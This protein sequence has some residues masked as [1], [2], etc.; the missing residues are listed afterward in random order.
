MVRHHDLADGQVR[1]L[2]VHDDRGRAALPEM[3]KL[4]GWLARRDEQETVDLLG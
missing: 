3:A 4:V 2:A 1:K